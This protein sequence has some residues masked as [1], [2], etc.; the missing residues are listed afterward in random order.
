MVGQTR[1]AANALT[2]AVSG[3][4]S[5][6]SLR[7]W[8][9][10][11]LIRRT[12]YVRR[13]PCIKGLFSDTALTEPILLAFGGLPLHIRSIVGRAADLWVFYVTG[14]LLRCITDGCDRNHASHR[15]AADSR[16]AMDTKSRIGIER[17]I[18]RPVTTTACPIFIAAYEI[19]AICSAM[20]E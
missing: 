3:A 14:Q 18:A 20:I 11:G 12:T 8:S 13:I 1:D 9:I 2:P 7:T 15:C 6:H 19:R 17:D 16:L 5:A 4:S 10:E